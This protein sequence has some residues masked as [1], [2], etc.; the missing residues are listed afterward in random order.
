VLVEAFTR[1]GEWLGGDS[2]RV[3]A[4]PVGE[5]W[6]VRFSVAGDRRPLAVPELGEP[7]VRLIVDTQLDGW[8]DASVR[9]RID[10]YL[11]AYRPR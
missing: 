3:A 2:L 5:W 6:R 8:L 7:L 11:P 4:E 1:I 10:I 9:D